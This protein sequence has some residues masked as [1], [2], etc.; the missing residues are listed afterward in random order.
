MNEP[1]NDVPVLDGEV[2]M[3]AV[4]V[5]GDDGSEVAPVFFGVGS[6]HGIDQTLG[7]RIPLITGVRRAVVKHG[8]VNGVRRLVRKDAGG[9]HGDELLNFVDAAAFHNVVVDENVL[10][11]EFDLEIR[12]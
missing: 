3:R 8:F 12:K 11:E 7:V 2:I 4:N 9:K 6:I 1:W 5:G 10:A